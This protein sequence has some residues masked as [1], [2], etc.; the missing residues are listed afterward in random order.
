MKYETENRKYKEPTM[1]DFNN[2]Q[3]EIAQR[4]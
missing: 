4:I 2:H 1:E 3:I